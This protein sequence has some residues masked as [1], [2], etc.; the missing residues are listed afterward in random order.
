MEN[1]H[2]TIG[3]AL[4]WGFIALY[5][6]GILKQINDLQQ[7]D[8]KSLLIFEVIFASAFLLIVIARFI[9]MRR[10]DTFI[11]AT[12]PVPR[13]HKILAKS[14]HSAMYLCLILLPI[15]G[16]V[17]AGL[18][19]QGRE[20]ESLMQFTLEIHGFAA[21]LS[22]VLIAIHIAAALW[23]RIKGEGVWTSMVPVFKEKGVSRNPTIQRISKLE[24]DLFNKLEERMQRRR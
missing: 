9:Y 18:F 13:A 3:K 6:Y 5:A 4:H 7:L 15:S 23:S 17:I 24:S 21:D 19:S 10:F 8:N 16:L 12:Q 2:T 1:S 22:Y 11:G 14:I 20:N